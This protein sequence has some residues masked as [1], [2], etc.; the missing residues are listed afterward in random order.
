MKQSK[1]GSGRCGGA[2]VVGNSYGVVRKSGAHN[3]KL[4]QFIFRNEILSY[5]NL[6]GVGNTLP[7]L[8]CPA[9]C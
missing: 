1:D 4:E 7:L 3:L 6:A 5:L 8:S 2:I 9:N